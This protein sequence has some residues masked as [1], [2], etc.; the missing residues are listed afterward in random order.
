MK[1]FLSIQERL[2]LI[3]INTHYTASV[4]QSASGYHLKMNPLEA[5]S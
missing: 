2:N 1:R 3:N 5:A 4:L